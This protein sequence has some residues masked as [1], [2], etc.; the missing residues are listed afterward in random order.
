MLRLLVLMI[1]I[2]LADSINPTTIA[3]ALYL[4]SCERPR[5]R[6]AEFTLAVFG[7]YLAGGALIAVGG[8]QLVSHAVGD[9]DIRQTVRYIGE[10]VAGVLLVGAAG[11]IWWRRDRLVAR[12]LPEAAPGRRSSALLGA[13]I[14]AVEL[15]T[16]FPYFAA[17]AAIIGSGLGAGQQFGLLVVFNICFVLPLIGILATL[18]V[19]GDRAEILLMRWRHYLE[20]RWPQVLAGLILL[21]G[22]IALLF[23]ATG[24]A[25][26][27]HGRVG[28]FFGGLH[29]ALHHVVH[30]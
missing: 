19:T 5:V 28:G 8:G 13:S 24:L 1:T 2:G 15:P 16:A 4:A 12:G 20:H 18:L 27:I 23:G 25:A 10:I 3:P 14:T 30:P 9:V 29:R 11:L 26:G 21:V 17:I 22:A 6:V 7:V